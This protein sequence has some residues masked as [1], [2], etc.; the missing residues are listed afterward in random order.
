MNSELEVG[1]RRG[2]R[3]EL[4][5]SDLTPRLCRPPSE[6][7]RRMLVSPVPR[8][9]SWSLDVGKMDGRAGWRL[10]GKLKLKL[11]EEAKLEE[12]SVVV[13]VGSDNHIGGRLEV[14]DLLRFRVREVVDR[15]AGSLNPARLSNAESEGEVKEL[16]CMDWRDESL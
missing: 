3:M 16:M 11:D 12:T 15:R 5:S 13:M 14:S 8:R 4:K 6:L 1:T 10:I 9:R 2:P 7:E